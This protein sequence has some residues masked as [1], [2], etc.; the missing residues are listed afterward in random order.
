MPGSLVERI[1]ALNADQALAA[2]EALATLLET[3]VPGNLDTTDFTSL[4]ADHDDIVGKLYAGLQENDVSDDQ[5]A[6]GARSL[7]LLAADLGFDAQV[8]VA[9]EAAAIHQRDFGALSGPLILAALAVVIA[10]IPKEQR[11][12]VSK[13]RSVSADGSVTEMEVTKS[14]VIRVGEEA[15]RSVADAIQKLARWWKEL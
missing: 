1:A 12:T 7:L 10:Y 4:V 2:A 9:L 6:G 15:V 14:E 8:E 11:T 13:L 3:E 5:V